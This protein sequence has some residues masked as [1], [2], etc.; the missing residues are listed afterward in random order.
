MN[1]Y[2][3]LDVAEN[4]T[5]EEIKA[6][7]RIQVQLYHPDRL[8]GASENVRRY[9][10]E[11]LKKINAAY[12]ILSDPQKR[13]DYD[14][15]ERAQQAARSR[16][17]YEGWAEPATEYGE[18]PRRNRRRSERDVAREWMRQEAELRKTEEFLR[19]QRQAAEEAERQRRA[20]EEAARRA[21][22]DCYP[23]AAL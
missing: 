5:T 18:R 9:A 16:V 8:L 12:A 7:Y 2:Q 3:L 15:R 20:A 1:L 21:S 17:V 13:R 10:E 6:A 22:R 19:R 23:R 14:A 11:R 4:A